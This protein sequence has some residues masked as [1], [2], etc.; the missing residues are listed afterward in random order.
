VCALLD[1]GEFPEAAA[2]LAR[3]TDLDGVLRVTVFEVTGLE[4]SARIEGGDAVI[5]ISPTFQFADAARAAPMILHELVH[6]AGAWP[7]EAV[8]AADELAAMQV[9]ASACDA[10]DFGDNPPRGCADAWELVAASD[11]I[12]LLVDAGYGAG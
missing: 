10:Y 9:Q 7:D 8:D 11:P 2:G 4:S 12:G 6:L 3:W 5:E 1:T